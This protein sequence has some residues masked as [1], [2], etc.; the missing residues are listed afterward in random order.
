MIS[1]WRSFLRNFSK[2]LLADEDIRSKAPPEVVESCW[3]GFEAA[4]ELDIQQA[5]ARL[6]VR[7]PPS[8]RSFLRVSNGWRHVSH[9]IDRLLPTFEIRW[10]SENNQD[11]IDAYVGPSRGLPY[12]SDEEYLVY[13]DGQ[14]PCK[15]RVEYL[16]TTLEISGVGDS[17]VYL[18]NPHTITPDGEWEAWSF[19]N[20]YPGAYRFRS[21]ADLLERDYKSL[22]HAARLAALPVDEDALV[23]AALPILRELVM[24][25]RLE[26]ADAAMEYMMRKKDD[27]LFEAW[28]FRG[29]T[30]PVFRALTE[31]AGR[32]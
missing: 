1:D 22:L 20:W 14:D 18:L 32:S 5:E 4:S 30:G 21:F 23:Q 31:V 6:G 28:I 24:I 19:A 17:A 2:A 3:L 7:L 12:L 29:G 25:H 8:Y 26:P 11:W 10:F 13:G 15:F 27:E 9:F 16:Q